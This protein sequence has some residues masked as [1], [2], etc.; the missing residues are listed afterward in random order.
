MNENWHY[1]QLNDANFN[2]PIRICKFSLSAT[3]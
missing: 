1:E 3:C 2:G